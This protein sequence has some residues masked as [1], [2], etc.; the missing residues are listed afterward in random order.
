MLDFQ[1]FVTGY[2]P[3]E[4]ILKPDSDLTLRP[5]M[6]LRWSASVGSARSEDTVV[7][8]RRGHEVVTEA[9][10]WPKVEVLVKGF[11]IPRPAILERT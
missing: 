8:D 2:A 6:A 10:R 1:G 4:M 3:R 9:Q 7:V 11:A 5:D